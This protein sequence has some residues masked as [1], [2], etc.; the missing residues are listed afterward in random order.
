MTWTANTQRARA[1]SIKGIYLLELYRTVD[2]GVDG[3]RLACDIGSKVKGNNTPE[4]L[5]DIFIAT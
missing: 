2:M 3:S 4:T 5:H 1:Y